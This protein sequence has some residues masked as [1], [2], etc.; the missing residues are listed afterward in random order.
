MLGFAHRAVLLAPT[1]DAFDH[2]AARLRHAIA[3]MPR[4]AFVDG[5]ATALAGFGRAI[6]LRHMRCDV[7]GAKIGHMIGRVIGL[8]RTGADAAAGGFA[9]GLEHD[10]R[11]AALGSAIGVRDHAGHRQPMPIFHDGVAHIGEFRLPPG[12]L[13]VRRLSG[14]LVLACVSF[15]RFWPWKFAPSSPLPSLGRKLF[16]EAQASISVPSTEKCS[17]DNSGLTCGWFRSW[18]MNFVNT[19]PVCSRSRFLVKVVGSQTGSSGDNPTNQRYK[20]L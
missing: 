9:L 14:S 12:G 4:G 13:A 5:A 11:G 8:V 1:E 20:R 17:S 3:L 2:G 16:C 19:S 10:L 15:L 7:A 6:V 18:V